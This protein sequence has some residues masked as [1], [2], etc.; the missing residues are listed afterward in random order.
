MPEGL[1]Q[2]VLPFRSGTYEASLLALPGG[3]VALFFDLGGTMH[4][5]TSAD[6]GRSWGDPRPLV[7]ASGTALSGFRTSPLLLAS[8]ALGLL[9]SGPHVR[10]GRDGPLLFSRSEDLGRTW[11]D[12]IFVDPI[13]AVARNGTGTVLSEGRIIAPV[14][15]WLSADATGASEDA[16]FSICYSFVYFSDDEGATWHK[17][18]SELF[19]SRDLG[20]AGGYSFEEPVVAELADGRLLM[21]GRTEMGRPYRSLSADR[22]YS[23][24]WPEPVH[25]ASAYTPFLLKPIPGTADVLGVWTQASEE[26]VL[27]GLM[28]HRL[29]AAVSGD[30]GVSWEHF[31]NLE[32]LDDTTRVAPPPDFRIIRNESGYHPPTDT[33]RYHRTSVHLRVCYP[34][35]AFVGDEVLVTYDFD[36]GP[37][38]PGQHGTKLR[39]LPRQWL[40]ES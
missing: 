37:D 40:T 35:V 17:S 29:T 2:M 12:P 6:A 4:M 15:V 22:G 33:T 11:T 1:E 19:V 9:W 3:E 23:W 13:F 34:S 24:S 30:A 28:R 31:R 36:A 7:T 32:S 20:R 16:D 5:K 21:Y 14:F 10:E 18:G 25:V 26:E 38:Q 8:G 39:I 27:A